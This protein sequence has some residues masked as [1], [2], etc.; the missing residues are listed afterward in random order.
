MCLCGVAILVQALAREFF[1][2]T[3]PRLRISTLFVDLPI[4]G[5]Q[6]G[7]IESTARRPFC[8]GSLQLAGHSSVNLIFCLL[9]ACEDSEGHMYTEL[10]PDSRNL[11]K[12]E[13]TGEGT[14]KTLGEVGEGIKII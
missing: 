1:A 5:M 7:D 8:K 10:G 11:L 2:E 14:P 4:L 9:T 13:S 12:L 3:D 6:S